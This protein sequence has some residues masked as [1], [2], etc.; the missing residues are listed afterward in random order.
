MT[1]T[2][3]KNRLLVSVHQCLIKYTMFSGIY[4]GMRIINIW[5][6]FL[7]LSLRFS[8]FF[9]C[10]RFSLS[11]SSFLSLFLCLRFC[12]SFFV[13]LSLSLFLCHSF[14]VSLSLSLSRCFSFSLFLSFPLSLSL[15]V[16]FSFFLSLSLFLSF[17]VSFFLSFFVSLSS[18]FLFLSLF[19][20]HS[21]FLC[22]SFSLSLSLFL[23]H[24]L[25]FSLIFFC[26]SV[27]LSLSFF[28]SFSV[29]LFFLPSLRF[30]SPSYFSR[31]EIPRSIVHF[32]S[33]IKSFAGNLLFTCM[34]QQIASGVLWQELNTKSQ[35]SRLP[36]NLRRRRSRWELRSKP[37]YTQT[38]SA[39]LEW[40]CFSE[41]FA[42][43]FS[44][45]AFPN[46]TDHQNFFFYLKAI[47]LFFFLFYVV[48]IVVQ[49]RRNLECTELG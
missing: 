42:S 25:C 35:L 5:L 36:E 8:L 28:L 2:T 29:S 4:F 32:C 44:F 33:L 45:S 7:F 3:V 34:Y 31:F 26:F 37:E 46:E 41:I 19:L 20:S 49:I 48:E 17:S 43:F 9:L 47:N 40:N 14:F 38:Y 1:I 23:S 18:L 21:L 15:F 27:S 13:T 11:L 24:F 22:F 39:L 12:H 6:A 16:F 10:L 30:S